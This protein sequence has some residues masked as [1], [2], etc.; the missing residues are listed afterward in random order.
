MTH[1]YCNNDKKRAKA[2]INPKKIRASGQP[3]DADYIFRT[4]ITADYPTLNVSPIYQTR[5]GMDT[6][7]RKPSQSISHRFGTEQ[8]M[9]P[10][11][12][13]AC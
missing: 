4:G 11:F 8:K 6:L 13:V 9:S 5:P 7:S 2:R 3:I 1:V 10:R 12:R